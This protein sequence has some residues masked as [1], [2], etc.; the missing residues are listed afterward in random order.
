MSPFIFNSG[1][2]SASDGDAQIDL[3]KG[4]RGQNRIDDDLGGDRRDSESGLLHFQ[5]VA[6]KRGPSP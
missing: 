4:D 2:S 1:S 3:G 6:L 5:I